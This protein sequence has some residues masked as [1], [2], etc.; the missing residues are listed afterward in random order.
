M[1]VSPSGPGVHPPGE[2]AVPEQ[3]PAG[4]RARM[5]TRLFYPLGLASLAA[6]MLPT[7]GCD[8]VD[9]GHLQD[10]TDPPKL[11]RL[12]I[13]DELPRGGRNIATDLLDQ[14]PA[15]ACSDTEPCPVGNQ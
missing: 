10:D 11:V 9:V 3:A 6:A 14:K 13:Q 7:L 1:V 12:M 2:G 15:I 5:R 8:D 4:E